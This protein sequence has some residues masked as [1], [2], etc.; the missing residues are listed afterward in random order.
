MIVDSHQSGFHK[1]VKF[2]PRAFCATIRRHLENDDSIGRLLSCMRRQD[3]HICRPAFATMYT[4]V[5]T[6]I[7]DDGKPD[8]VSRGLMNRRKVLEFWSLAT[9]IAASR[10]LGLKGIS[11][12]YAADPTCQTWHTYYTPTH[13]EYLTRAKRCAKLPTRM[14]VLRKPD[15]STITW[16]DQGD[17][18]VIAA[19]VEELRKGAVLVDG[20]PY[21]VPQYSALAVSPRN[22]ACII[23]FERILADRQG[24]PGTF[25]AYESELTYAVLAL[26]S[27][28]YAFLGGHIP[29]AVSA[30]VRVEALVALRDHKD[31]G[32]TK[33]ELEHVTFIRAVR[34]G[35]MTDAIWESMRRRVGSERG[36]T[37]YTW[38][39]AFGNAFHQFCWAVGAPELSREDFNAMLVK[40]KPDAAALVG[41]DSNKRPPPNRKCID[42][43]WRSYNTP[44]KQELLKR[45]ARLPKLPDRDT[46]P[47]NEL[48]AYDYTAE[49]VEGFKKGWEIIDGEG[50][51]VPEWSAYAVSPMLGAEIGRW[52][53]TVSNDEGRLGGMTNIQHEIIDETL[54]LD[55]GYYFFLGGHTP[56]AIS[57]GIRI[58]ALEALRDH[59]DDLLT[60]DELQLIQF[61]RAVRDGGVTDEMWGSMQMLL[62][63]ERAVFD[64]V[65]YVMHLDMHHRLDRAFGCP[66]IS[67]EKFT[68]MLAE[69]RSGVRKAPPYKQAYR[70]S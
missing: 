33:E 9:L 65:F 13:Q 29:R 38:V 59:R 54:A 23:R 19:R 47:E 53:P 28:Y 42:T 61:I 26:D 46:I 58:E 35:K 1:T 30:G 63:N 21:G 15:R 49:R 25:T 67:R 5:I 56:G 14:G 44:Q 22:G 64:Y 43:P 8:Q 20:E 62:G 2:G 4:I 16:E 3:Y 39:A 7:L 57:A 17:Y 41:A 69:Y 36:V 52:G 50:Y 10:G 40:L 12:A 68:I 55:S 24:S 70:S 31:I 51:A 60:K 11:G 34:D 6:I 32:L 48:L 18:E 27:G 66:E 45:A 37:E